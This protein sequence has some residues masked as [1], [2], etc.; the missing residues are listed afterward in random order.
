MIVVVVQYRLGLFGFLAGDKVKKGGALNAGLR[1]SLF[2]GYIRGIIDL[3][4]RSRPTI[5]LAM[6]AEICPFSSLHMSGRKQIL[7]TSTDQ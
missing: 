7:I 6:G 2:H 5:C 4:S 1:K 3:S